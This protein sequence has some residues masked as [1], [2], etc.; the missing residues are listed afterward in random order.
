[1]ST[2]VEEA[3]NETAVGVEIAPTN[4]GADIKETDGVNTVE[5]ALKVND[6]SAQSVTPAS[7]EH[8]STL[9]TP[10]VVL[11]SG[12]I[13]PDHFIVS[14]IDQEK[15][16]DR[17]PDNSSADYPEDKE[18]SE[19]RLENLFLKWDD[20]IES[21]RVDWEGRCEIAYGIWQETAKPGCKGGFRVALRRLK[22]P[23]S[24]A[25][26]MV[27]RHKVKIGEKEDPDA[28]DS[29]DEEEKEE[30]GS[31][32]SKSESG[33]T[34]NRHHRSGRRRRS[35]SSPTV[36]IA[37]SGKIA[38]AVTA[39]QTY[40]NQPSAAEVIK[41]CVLR[42]WRELE[43]PLGSRVADCSSPLVAPEVEATANAVSE[44]VIPENPT[45]EPSKGE[46]SDEPEAA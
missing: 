30:E 10:G 9:I 46:V 43:M 29:R 7:D 5:A 25:Y 11:D 22:L 18:F 36:A 31:D 34:R 17:L 45:R 28:T 37:L 39:I 40:Y 8:V 4:K 3:A 33:G 20:G 38:E 15:R 19:S 13:P 12:E 32:E 16:I 23:A 35:Q 44:P 14:A 2:C 24:T 41:F 27:N 26:D 21:F 1:M 6:Y 42:V